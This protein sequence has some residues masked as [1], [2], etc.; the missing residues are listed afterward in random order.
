MGRLSTIRLED[1][2]AKLAVGARTF[3]VSRRETGGDSNI[4]PVDMI[5]GALGS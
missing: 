1:G 2:Q 3:S 5:V 4:C